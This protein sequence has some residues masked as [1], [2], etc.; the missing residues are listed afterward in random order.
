M[1]IMYLGRFVDQ[2]PTEEVFF[3]P[4][5]P[6]TEALLSANPEPDPDAAK[7]RVEICGEV[8]SLTDRPGG[9]KFHTR[10]LYL[11]DACRR[12]APDVSN[13]GPQHRFTCDHP[14]EPLRVQR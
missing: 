5:H 3:R 2:G 6:Y 7:H 1:A 10:C 4:R 9:C 11:Q 14:L 12:I 8:P 13:E